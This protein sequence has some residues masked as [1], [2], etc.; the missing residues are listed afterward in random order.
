VYLKHALA[1]STVKYACALG[2]SDKP[3]LCF[4]TKFDTK[5]ALILIAISN[6]YLNLFLLKI[7]LNKK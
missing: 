1:L 7:D 2:Y 4:D 6:N 3:L 5:H